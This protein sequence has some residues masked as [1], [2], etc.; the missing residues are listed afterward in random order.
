MLL[1]RVLAFGQSTWASL[2]RAVRPA[3]ASAPTEHLAPGASSLAQALAP[4]RVLLQG[5]SSR[6]QCSARQASM[7]SSSAS[8]LSLRSP[9]WHRLVPS[10]YVSSQR[11]KSRQ[12]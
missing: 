11:A 6:T 12:A 9:L 8:S 7:G 3:A 5:R 2:E 4:V 10:V 1:P